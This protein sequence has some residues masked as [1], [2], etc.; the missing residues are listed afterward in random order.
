MVSW[1]FGALARLFVAALVF[2]RVDPVALGPLTFFVFFCTWA[3][4]HLAAR[5][6][7]S[8]VS[9]PLVFGP[10]ALWSLGPVVPWPIGLLAR[11]L[12]LD[13]GPS[14]PW[15]IG[16]FGVYLCPLAP[17][18]SL[19][20][21]P[22]GP[23]ALRRLGVSAPSAPLVPWP[24]GPLALWSIGPWVPW[25]F[26]ALALWSIGAGPLALWS[27]GPLLVPWPFGRTS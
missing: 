5:S 11:C 17:F 7:G 10:L 27:I 25:P 23:L 22:L 4:R 24:I 21:W 15:P 6:I 9:W 8:M 18:D 3:P 13:L 16:P 26:G 14:L 20:P 2:W 1:P 12:V 19:V